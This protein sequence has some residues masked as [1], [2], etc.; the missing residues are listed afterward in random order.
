[1]VPG[2]HA[3]ATLRISVAAYLARFKGQSEFTPSRTCARSSTGATDRSW[4]PWRPSAHTSRCSSAGCR[5]SAVT[6]IHRVTPAVGGGRL[7]PHLRHRRPPGASPADYVRCP[8][9]SGRVTDTG[10]HPSAVRGIDRGRQSP[11]LFD[12][13]L[14]DDARPPRAADL[15]G[16]RRQ[17]RRPRRGARPP[18]AARAGQGRQ[19]RAGPVATRRG[20]SDR[21]SGRRP[22]RGPILLNRTGNRMDRHCATRRLR[23]PRRAGRASQPPGCIPHAPTHLRHHNARR[24]VDLRDVQI[25]A[26]HADPRTTMRYDRARKN[27]DRHPNYVLAAY[28]ASGT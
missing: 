4:T 26:R 14:V 3:S 17:H 22:C 24:R 2:D 11:N 16:H 5:R 21:P 12:F 1:M 9:V 20:P 10:P 25:A 8:P 18:R 6:T 19:N 27:L 23:A 7:L 13:A 15:R 28:M